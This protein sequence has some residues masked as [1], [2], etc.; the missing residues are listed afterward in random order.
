M[1]PGIKSTMGENSNS[2]L[3]EILAPAGNTECFLAALAAGAD[4]VYLGL[5]QFSARMEAENFDLPLLGRLIALAHKHGRKVYVAMNNLI[6]PGELEQAWRLTR[7]LATQVPADGLI[8]QDLGMV[9]LARQAAF[10]NVLAFSTLANVSFPAALAQAAKMGANR[11][12]IPREL[13][14]DEMRLMGETAPPGLNLECFVHGALCYCVSGRCYWSSYLGG[15]SGLRGRCVQPCRRKYRL[16]GASAGK[17]DGKRYFACQDLEIGI[18]AK[19]LL[20]VPNLDCWKIEGRKK[21]PHYVFHVV[22]AYRL[23]RDNPGNSA[24]KKMA[25]AILELALGRPGVK[26]NFLSQRPV[27]P[28]NPENQTSSGLLAGKIAFNQKGECILR[29]RLDLIPGDYLRIGIEDERWHAT[30]PVRR[31]TPK[32][33]SL[34]LKVDKHKTPKTGTSVFLIDRREQDLAK[35]LAD[36]RRQ[37]EELPAP[38][39]REVEGA[40]AYPKKRLQQSVPDMIVTRQP[41]GS[42]LPRGAAQALWLSPECL[43]LPCKNIG[44]TF[45][46]LPPDLWPNNQAQT[47]RIIAS[48]LKAGARNFVC[49]SPWQRI[50]FP[51][52]SGNVLLVAGPFCNTS[53]ALAIGELAKAGFAAT[54]AS[55]ELP[56]EDLKKLARQSCLPIGLALE[57]YFPV[58]ISRFG[59]A[60]LNAG[61]V[62]TSPKGEAFWT[63]QYAGSTWIY[64]GWKLDLREKRKEL[65]K[66]GFSFFATLRETPPASLA[67][68][69]RPGLFNWNGDLP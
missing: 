43:K 20:N 42:H 46:W 37:L 39:I 33:G 18:I 23:L 29:P 63:G 53:N 44:A 54:F 22:T 55:Q 32:G 35:I 19:T 45:F 11:V 65:E 36:W 66:A 4:A 64:P 61:D 56:G 47:E 7:L 12:I 2:S 6:R 26:A 8:I 68:K 10:K 38:S 30:I 52:K 17:D 40:P 58:G 60:G 16:A 57:G 59:L 67:A 14:L 28:M 15:K 25:A 34:A 48:L 41:S 3:P 50:F 13:S 1:W 69:S 51:E 9:A 27:Q 31:G 21:G 24:I 5:K 62:F 49:N